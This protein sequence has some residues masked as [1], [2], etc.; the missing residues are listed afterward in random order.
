MQAEYAGFCVQTLFAHVP[1]CASHAICLALFPH[2]F[3]FGSHAPPLA[4]HAF[5]AAAACCVAVGVFGVAGVPTLTTAD[6]AG[7]LA[8][9]VVAAGVES[10]W[11]AA[12]AACAPAFAA[13]AGFWPDALAAATAFLRAAATA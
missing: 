6:C 12:T 1:L 7:W 4:M 10:D 13:A 5:F 9:G 8:A 3:E 11:R 2:E